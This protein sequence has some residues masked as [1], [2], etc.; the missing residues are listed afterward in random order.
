MNVLDLIAVTEIYLDHVFHLPVSW[1]VEKIQ[2]IFV[3]QRKP[4]G[5]PE[6]TGL[7]MSCKFGPWGSPGSMGG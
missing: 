4:N 6:R 3:D 2:K 1:S 5:E 7:K